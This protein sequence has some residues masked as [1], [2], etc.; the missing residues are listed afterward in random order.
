[1]KEA[2]T[3]EDVQEQAIAAAQKRAAE[4][5]AEK[6][7]KGTRVRVG[8]T[9]GRN[10]K[11]ITWEAFDTD[12]PETLPTTL[13][14]FMSLA[15]LDKMAKPE[16]QL[17]SYL[18][19]GFNSNQYAV[20]SDVLAEFVEPN[21]PDALVRQFKQTV[22]NYAA[23]TQMSLEDTVALIKPGIVKAFDARM[24]AAAEVEKK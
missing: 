11:V 3:V 24:K 17:V 13:D 2:T 18:I 4:L 15:G 5:N 23:A 10:P 12:A 7:G 8:Q 22:S 14:E 16:P 19:D 21:W 6:K 20:A 1:M 9:R